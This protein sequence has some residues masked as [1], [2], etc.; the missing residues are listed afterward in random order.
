MNR[1][2]FIYRGSGLIAGGMLLNFSPLRL[3]GNIASP[4]LCAVKSADYYN[5]AIRAVHEL[6]GI[7]KF[8]THGS[9]VGFLINS[10]FEEPGTYPKPDIALAML[11]LCWEAGAREI[12]MLQ[13]VS[14]DYWRRSKNF[15]K[16]QFITDELKQV[17]AN[18]HPAVFND[19]D[20]RV[21]ETIDGA[22]RLKNI[23]IIR[24]ISEVDVFINIPILKH[25]A[26]T[27]LTGAMKNMM[28][29]CTRKT[30]VT[31]HL[32]SGVRNDP[33]YLGQCIADLNLVRKPN[34]IVADASEFITGN[35][36]SGP[37]PLK[38]LDVVV[39]GTD[40]VAI[41]AF[42]AKCLDME[43][44]DIITVKQAYELG[45]GEMDLSKLSVSEIQA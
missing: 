10:N 45:I 41:D 1:R 23:E 30:N 38:K 5:S 9:S 18:E 44:G 12:V 15:A 33:E 27:I 39:A 7:N 24:K 35:G 32:G 13:A 40:P 22:I 43:A 19:K 11:F 25:H 6:G 29:L 17:S 2:R 21:I 31:F 14:K 8:V 3:F 4:D 26:S 28:G 20:F 37:G 36:P 42:G 34:L 16:H